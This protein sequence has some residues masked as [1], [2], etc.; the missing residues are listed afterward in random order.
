MTLVAPATVTTVADARAGLSTTLKAFRRSADSA[1]VVLGSHRKP[2]AVLVPFGQYQRLVSQPYPTASVLDQLRSR[3]D[4]LHRLAALNNVGE[5]AVFG[6]VARGTETADSDIDFL[7][8]PH[9]TTGH[10]QLAQ[11]AIDLEQLFERRVDVVSRNALDPKG[12]AQILTEA[13]SL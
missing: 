1:P 11:L 10:F 13:I 2:E 4:L 7:V 12:D 6:S 5:I 8:E 9:E 3:R